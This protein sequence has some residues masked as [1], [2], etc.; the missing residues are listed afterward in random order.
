M[1][2]GN[3]VTYDQFV[4]WLEENPDCLGI[5]RW[6]LGPNSTLSLSNKVD[7]PT[8]YQ[9]LAGVTHLEEQEIVEL[10]KRFW[11]LSANSNQVEP[12]KPPYQRP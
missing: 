11:I 5:C 12:I 3:R 1:F 4:R 9:T 2:Q 6:I 7:T 10:E 8:F